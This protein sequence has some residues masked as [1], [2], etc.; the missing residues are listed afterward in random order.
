MY[1]DIILIKYKHTFICSL[2]YVDISICIYVYY[3]LQGVLFIYVY[4][5]ISK[6]MW[7]N[8]YLYR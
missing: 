7:I 4:L 2:I 5:Y 8:S 6:Y 1:I 3:I